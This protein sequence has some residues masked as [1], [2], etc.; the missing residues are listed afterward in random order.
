V[1]VFAS[2]FIFFWLSFLVPFAL[3]LQQFGTGTCHFAWH[4]AFATFWNG[5]FAFC[6]VSAT[7]GH[8]RFPFCMVFA[9]FWHFNLSFAWHLLHLGT[10]NIDVGF[11]RVL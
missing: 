6:M 1:F 3:Y 10:L 11:L 7:F 8:V 9:T 4:L 2:G 5:H